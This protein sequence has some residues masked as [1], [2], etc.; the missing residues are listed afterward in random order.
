FP[1]SR[2]QV[3][4]YLAPRL[5]AFGKASKPPWAVLQVPSTRRVETHPLA[6]LLASK[7]VRDPPESAARRPAVSFAEPA[8][9]R[10]LV[11][12][13]AFG[14]LGP[15]GNPC[16]WHQQRTRGNPA[17]RRR[18]TRSSSRGLPSSV[19]SRSS[20]SR[21][22]SADCS[23]RPTHRPQPPRSHRLPAE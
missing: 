12:L 19:L 23:A 8:N 9:A 18:S 7:R 15:A 21:S 11:A 16:K 1:W 5:E 10:R 3:R 20:S 6:G 17:K 13:R 14:R 4:P 22:R 2:S